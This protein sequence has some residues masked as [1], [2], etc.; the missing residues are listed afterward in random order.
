MSKTQGDQE[1]QES[2]LTSSPI[3]IIVVIRF[4]KTARRLRLRYLKQGCRNKRNYQH[5]QK[6]VNSE[7]DTAKKA[8]IDAV[9]NKRNCIWYV[10]NKARNKR[11]ICAFDT[12]FAE[13]VKREFTSVFTPP[14]TSRSWLPWQM[15]HKMTGTAMLIFIKSPSFRLSWKTRNQL[16]ATKFLRNWSMSLR[17]TTAS[18]FSF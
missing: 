6:K 11:E 15:S 13:S 5:Y 10:I 12:E 18:Y 3:A 2:S 17:N 7:I 14:L 16:V 4:R 9:K 1:L 8:W